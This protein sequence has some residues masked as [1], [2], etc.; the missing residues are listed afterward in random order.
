MLRNKYLRCSPDITFE[1][2]KKIWDKLIATGWKPYVAST[3]AEDMYKKWNRDCILTY[4]PSHTPNT[5]GIYSEDSSLSDDREVF[6]ENLINISP[7]FVLPPRWYVVVTKENAEVLSKWRWPNESYKLG[8]G[9]IVGICESDDNGQF[10]LHSR[11]HNP[12]KHTASF[13]D[14]EI[15]YEQFQKYVLKEDSSTFPENWNIKITPEIRDYLQKYDGL[16]GIGYDYTLNAYY[17]MVDGHKYGSMSQSAKSQSVTFKMLK[18]HLKLEEEP[19][20]GYKTEITASFVLPEKWCIRVDKE[21]YRVL[22]KWRTDGDLDSTNFSYYI[23]YEGY[24]K[25]KGY[26]VCSIPDGVTLISFEQFK[27]FVL[28]EEDKEFCV[29]GDGSSWFGKMIPLYLTSKGGKMVSSWNYNVRSYFFINN[30]SQIEYS[31]EPKGRIVTKTEVMEALCYKGA[32]KG[33]IDS[34]GEAVI[35]HLKEKGATKNTNWTGCDDLFYYI[36]VRD[37]AYTLEQSA[38]V[39]EGY[40]EEFIKKSIPSIYMGGIKCDG[41]RDYGKK[42]IQFL[43]KAGGR[44]LSGYIGSVDKY[45]YINKEGVIK[46]SYSL[47][48]DYTEVSRAEVEDAYVEEIE[49]VKDAPVPLVEVYAKPAPVV[50]NI[51]N[52][53]FP[54]VEEIL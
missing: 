9:Q 19:V 45:Y 47:P 53:Y 5:F 16:Y 36:V 24:E 22:S 12:I 8:P 10:R 11:G 33:G 2:F 25:R 37:E 4:G 17:G 15:T 46:Y 49:P 26:C 3:G 28:G 52:I 6:V 40:H 21:N 20:K 39:P 32:I 31:P 35:A 43:V 13:G 14:C 50:E 51:T 44:N 42:A 34:H 23:M 48:E 38:L 27:R 29:Q 1:I 30:S 54:K 18:Q 41:D 7:K